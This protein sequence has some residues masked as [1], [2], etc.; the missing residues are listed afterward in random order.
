MNHKV[1]MLIGR[2]GCG[3]SSYSKRVCEQLN[4]KYFS[5]GDL[6]RQEV[7]RGTDI[8]TEAAAYVKQGRL[9][10]DDVCNKL[11]MKCLA[12]IPKLGCSAIIDGYPRTVDQVKYLETNHEKYWEDKINVVQIDVDHQVVYEKMMGRRSCATCGRGF[13]LAHIVDDFYDMPAILP[14]KNTCPSGPDNCNPVLES[15]AD[16]VDEETINRRLGM[17]CM[18]MSHC[19]RP[20]YILV[21][22]LLHLSCFYSFVDRCICL[23]ISTRIPPRKPWTM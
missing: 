21:R 7:E 9:I 16:D 1:F 12:D 15:R 22:Q 6:I 10:G 20:I 4:W 8:G 5:M 18:K 2:P 23:Q 17:N 19:T 14:D 11:I 13:N 3:K